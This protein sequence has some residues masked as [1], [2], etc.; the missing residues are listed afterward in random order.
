MGGGQTAGANANKILGAQGRPVCWC[1]FNGIGH[2][3]QGFKLQCSRHVI[4]CEGLVGT[5]WDTKLLMELM[6]VIF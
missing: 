2:G 4:K 3:C 5:K 1:V 6:R